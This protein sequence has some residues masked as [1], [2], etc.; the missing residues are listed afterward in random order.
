MVKWNIKEQD[1]SVIAHICTQFHLDEITARLLYNRGL[2]D[3]KSIHGFFDIDI[4]HLHS[5]FLLK[6]MDRAVVRIEKAIT[7]GEKITVYG[8]YDVDG[9]TSV[10]VLYKYLQARGANAAYY[11]PDRAGEGYGLNEHALEQIQNNGTK[12][13]ITVDT[14]TTAVAEVAW[15]ADNGL[16]VVVTD[17]HECKAQLPEC[18]LVNPKRADSDYPF[19]ELAG[20]GVVFKLLCALE[21][22]DRT[23]FDAYGDLVAIGTI[24]DI[25]PLVD[26]NRV[27]VWL[28]LQ[29]MRTKPS[30]P[31]KALL[32]ASGGNRNIAI[33]AGTV[34]FQIAPRLNAAGRIGDP[35]MSVEL[36]LS[37][38]YDTA[39]SLSQALCEENRQRQQMEQDI[40]KDVEE[41]IAK[42]AGKDKIIVV[43]SEHWHH[44]VIGIVA[45]R[46]VDRYH[47]PCIL[48]CFDGEHAK[49]SARSIKGVSMF[50]L[51]CR[52]AGY[53]D[54]FGGHEMAAG[55]TLSRS[56]YDDFVAAVTKVANEQITDDMLI[57]VMEAE[58]ELSARF[59]TLKTARDLCRLEPY[60]AGNPTPAFCIQQVRIVD[61]F[62]VGMGKHIKLILDL[63][64]RELTAMY[65]GMKLPDFD[66]AVG[67]EVS[68]ICSL[69]ENVFNHKSSLTLHIKSIRPQASVLAENEKYQALYETYLK[70]G[71]V[72]GA[73]QMCRAD[74]VAVYRYLIRQ[75][76]AQQTHFQP[77]ALSRV[78]R[79][80]VSEFNYCRL[81]LALRVFEEL[82]ILQA[83]FENGLE[84][85]FC[86]T[87]SKVNLKL[88]PT[89]RDIEKEEQ[90]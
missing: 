9:I 68:I 57:P 7:S 62:S 13:V 81:R 23:V 38:D 21:K 5:P 53:L 10:V 15:A 72:T 8:D 30:L 82:G 26:E 50:D 83:H 18:I 31:V 43:A 64:G 51:L 19:T 90:G 56:G 55:L 17:H 24:A 89:W 78:L 88:S 76:H 85:V 60:G 86:D 28:G 11:I 4:S 6:D 77:F 54:K 52:V 48:I 84:I 79:G 34:A 3:E 74:M 20:V 66:Y 14:G 61:M 25:M 35:G 41:M 65:F 29:A 22:N 1:R 67:D 71:T 73:M 32:E 36:M 2:V 80:T 58:C 70:E 45:S 63:D 42:G 16:D 75:M 40:L 69:T 49:G 87:E 46:I 37:H 39:R 33:N 27:I 44:G 12:L 59:V 47:K